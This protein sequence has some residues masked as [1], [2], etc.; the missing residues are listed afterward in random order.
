MKGMVTHIVPSADPS[1]HSYL[2]KIV[3]ED[4]SSI[5]VGMFARIEFAMGQKQ[6]ITIPGTAIVTRADLPGVYMVDEQGIA[7]FRMVRTGRQFND[8]V[9]IISGLDRGDRIVL[10]PASAVKTGDRITEG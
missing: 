5:R 9:E 1:T 2:V 3:L 4:V 7:H 6:V 8:N 10:A